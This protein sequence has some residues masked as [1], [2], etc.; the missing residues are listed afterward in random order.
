VSRRSAVA[1]SLLAAMA[2]ASGSAEPA[3]GADPLSRIV[4]DQAPGQR[5][6]QL[7]DA[8]NGAAFVPRGSNYVRLARTPGGTEFHATFEPGIY[9]PAR[10]EAALAA[11]QRDGYNTVRVFTDAGNIPDAGAGHPHGLGRGVAD[12]GTV[13]PPYMDNVADFVRR[14][15]AHC[16]RVIV[17]L[18]GFPANSH[19]YT[20]VADRGPSPDITGPNLW[21][22][23]SMHVQAKAAFVADFVRALRDRLGPDRLSAILAY[24]IE[25]EAHVVANIKPFGSLG[26]QTVTTANGQTYDMRN[27]GDRQRAV[28]D[29]FTYFANRMAAAIRSVDPG[30]LVTM[31][32]F[33]HAAV[34][35]AGPDGLAQNCEGAGCPALDYR[36]PAR[37][38]L[39]AR[40]TALSFLDIHVYP[41]PQPGGVNDPYTLARDLG[42]S[43]W[44]AIAGKPVILGEYG[45][46]KTFWGDDLTRA[47]FGMRDLQVETCRMGFGGWLYWTWDTHEPLAGQ[48]RFFM[49]DERGGAINGQLAP[50]ARP[51][52]CEPA[53]VSPYGAPTSCSRVPPKL[54]PPAQR[55]TRRRSTISASR[56]GVRLTVWRSS[57]GE[58]L[59]RG[60]RVAVRVPRKGRLT[61]TARH[62]KRRIVRRDVRFRKAGVR[63]MRMRIKGTRARTRLRRARPARITV[64]ARFRPAG[65]RRPTTVRVRLTLRRGTAAT[66]TYSEATR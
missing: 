10:V 23:D 54:P 59:R 30:A 32:V 62:R 3:L 2:A 41:A 39:L 11:M 18:D 7:R 26:P 61:V 21:T 9:D 46:L 63:R 5:F 58:A 37:P 27:L 50:I 36:Y 53:V 6:G 65:R 49:L 55:V 22:L 28:D 17:N 56:R 19:Y 51:D 44:S 38:A 1:I 31:G 66:A 34:G 25:N 40:D 35:K 43:E 60:L 12:W 29:G 15:D 4:V 64:Q 16:L 33:T 45:A 42:T 57:L 24:Q 20:R 14:A 48:P 8:A 13:Y 47:A 52:P